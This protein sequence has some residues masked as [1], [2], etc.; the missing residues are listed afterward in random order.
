[1]IV[2]DYTLLNALESISTVGVLGV[3]ILI[4]WRGATFVQWVTSAL[5]AVRTELRYFA[6]ANDEA[7]DRLNSKLDSID[8]RVVRIEEGINGVRK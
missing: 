6:T 4:A 3:L 7:N 5:E 1:V 2:V 8:D